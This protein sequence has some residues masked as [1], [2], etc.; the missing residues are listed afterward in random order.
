MRFPRETSSVLLVTAR[1]FSPAVRLRKKVSNRREGLPSSLR[2]EGEFLSQQG[3]VPKMAGC[4]FLT[5]PSALDTLGCPAV[6]RLALPLVEPLPDK[7]SR[8]DI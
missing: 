6:R 5:E 1:F 4:H 3:R 7:F 2:L 8:T